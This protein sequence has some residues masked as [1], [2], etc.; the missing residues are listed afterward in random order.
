[1]VEHE[2]WRF[3]ARVW[4]WANGA[5]LFLI[6]GI[7]VQSQGQSVF[8]SS[9]RLGFLFSEDRQTRFG[10][11]DQLGQQLAFAA[12]IALFL[13]LVAPEK[14][15][16]SIVSRP[17]LNFGLFLFLTTGCLLTG[18][19][20]AYGGLLVGVTVLVGSRWRGI[21]LSRKSRRAASVGV[22]MIA[23]ILTA[24]FGI[25]I[26]KK[27]EPRLKKLDRVVLLSG[28]VEIWDSAF[29]AWFSSPQYVLVGAGTGGAESILG[30]YKELSPSAD[31]YGD[32]R[33]NPHSSY[34]D[35]L[36]SY[37]ILGLVPGFWLLLRLW[38]GARELDLQGR[39]S[40]RTSVLLFLVTQASVAVI[41]R[42]P[43]WLATAPLFL[44]MV[45]KQ[46]PSRSRLQVQ[47]KG[48]GS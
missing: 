5:A 3:C 39:L 6:L 14:T 30:R 21:L 26:W 1:M 36:L 27:A 28:R 34:I 41:Y 9:L 7:E 33:K 11:P 31:R 24:T 42:R 23:A 10:N 12:L 43:D 4:I 29:Q 46:L 8:M 25:V 32:L 48:V 13:S 16:V 19:L 18:S 37:G 2:L 40:L 35:W 47:I 38:G 44:A 20:G 15:N 17:S 22:L 45:S